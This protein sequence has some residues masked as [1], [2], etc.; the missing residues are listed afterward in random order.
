MTAKIKIKSQP[1]FDL[2]TLAQKKTEELSQLPM[3]R[4]LYISILGTILNLALVIFTQ[5]NLPPQIPL[6]YGFPEGEDQLGSSTSLLI[7][8]SVAIGIIVLNA[9][10]ILRLKNELMQKSLVVASFVVSVF[11]LVT[12][13]KILLLVGRF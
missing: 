1:K 8:P 3:T 9:I 11:S 7:P 2:G 13:I 5:N 4:L 12:T 10:I 6:F